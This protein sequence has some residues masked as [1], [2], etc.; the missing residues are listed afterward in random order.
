MYFSKETTGFYP[1][2][3]PDA[4]SD[5]VEITSEEHLALIAGQSE[6]WV[7]A[8]DDEGRPYLEPG[9]VLLE[10]MDSQS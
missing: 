8:A 6:G 2:V 1:S 4:P 10:D 9:P 7:I 3:Y 5:L